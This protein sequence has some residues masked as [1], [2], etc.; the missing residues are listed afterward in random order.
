MVLCILVA[1]IVQLF[2]CCVF[3]GVLALAPFTQGGV[4][5][6]C[7]RSTGTCAIKK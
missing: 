7:L 4:S 6:N 3:F 5:I 1:A 2:D